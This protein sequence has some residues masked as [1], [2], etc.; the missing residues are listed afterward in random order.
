MGFRLADHKEAGP[1]QQTE[2]QGHICD[3]ANARVHVNPSRCRN[4]VDAIDAILEA[5]RASPLRL[6][7]YREVE[8]LVGKLVHVQ[9]TIVGAR[10]A[11]APLHR[12]KTDAQRAWVRPT[13]R[14]PRGASVEISAGVREALGWWRR[15][16]SASQ[17][18]T[19]QLYTFSDGTMDFWDTDSVLSPWCVPC[20]DPVLVI[21]T[22]A[23]ACGYGVAVGDTATPALTWAGAWSLT[24]SAQTS[25][26]REHRAQLEALLIAEKHGFLGPPAPPQVAKFVLMRSDNT[27]SVAVTAKLVSKAQGVDRVTREIGEFLRKRPWLRVKSIHVP[28]EQNVLADAL[29]RAAQPAFEAREIAA[30]LLLALHRAGLPPL[31][32][33]VGMAAAS[34]RHHPLPPAQPL[35][36]L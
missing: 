33:C 12:A 10:A 17:P 4:I 28:G 29:S 18:P 5:A 16:L 27:C 14:A 7:A 3:F 15:H 21:A 13:G 31:R 23:A 30:D 25:N 1:E 6:A 32:E 11:L 35:S 22:D 20:G 9:F 34:W 24:Q 8:S 2:H 19:M 26:F 36:A